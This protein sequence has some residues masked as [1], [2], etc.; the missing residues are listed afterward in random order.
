MYRVVVSSNA[1][2]YVVSNAFHCHV[3]KL[4]L[5]VAGPEILTSVGR[6]CLTV[7]KHHHLHVVSTQPPRS[8]RIIARLAP[9]LGSLDQLASWRLGKGCE[10]AD[11]V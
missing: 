6:N 3:V 10:Y 9:V 4:S 8:W 5:S 1:S 11:I 2:F 7:S